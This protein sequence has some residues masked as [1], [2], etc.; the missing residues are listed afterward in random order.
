MSLTTLMETS[1][2][3]RERIRFATH[4]TLRGSNAHTSLERENKK[5]EIISVD[6]VLASWK[7][8]AQIISHAVKENHILYG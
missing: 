8:W 5:V 2:T 3:I 4:S 1:G 6:H 7:T